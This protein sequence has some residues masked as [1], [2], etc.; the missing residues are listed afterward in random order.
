MPGASYGE[1]DSLTRRQEVIS[2]IETA[3]WRQWI[4]QVLPN[5]VPYRRWKVEHRSP[6][7]GDVV[8]VLYDKK[9]GKGDYRLGRIISV[10]PDSH[11]CV[12][13]V[14]VG[15]RSKDRDKSAVYVPK[16]L[17]ELRLGVQRIAVIYPVEEQDL[18][19]ED[20]HLNRSKE[21]L[22]AEEQDLVAEERR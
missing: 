8:L 21:D 20:Q 9:V 14:V 17:E 1:G 2:E 22:D 6:K 7:P 12:R 10:H 16:P 11:G 18:V 4:V 15:V 3:W 19:A 5:L 13:T